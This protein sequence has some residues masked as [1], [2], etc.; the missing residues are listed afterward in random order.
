MLAGFLSGILG[1]ESFDLCD[2]EFVGIGFLEGVFLVAE[3]SG[4]VGDLDVRC[5]VDE[6]SRFRI[7]ESALRHL[8]LEEGLGMKQDRAQPFP[9][10]RQ[11]L[12]ILGDEI[13]H[14]QIVGL[15]GR[16]FSGGIGEDLTA[17]RRQ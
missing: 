9:T 10:L 5:H 1:I 15:A 4:D 3:L 17:G 14:V 16:V 12:Q 13:D 11:G 8:F 6:E 7:R 2:G